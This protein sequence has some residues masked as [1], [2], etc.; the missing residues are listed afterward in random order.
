MHLIDHQNNITKNYFF[1]VEWLKTC[2]D[3]F[4]DHQNQ[5]LKKIIFLRLEWLKTCF[6]AFLDNQNQILKK[7]FF[8]IWSG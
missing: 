3:A 4:I 2:F 8:N 1:N 7:L 6:D 5:V